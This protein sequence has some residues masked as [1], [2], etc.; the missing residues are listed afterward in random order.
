MMALYAP[1]AV[2]IAKDGVPA[3]VATSCATWRSVPPPVDGSGCPRQ[4]TSQI[5]HTS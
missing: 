3:A 5:S 1:E 2:F 4:R